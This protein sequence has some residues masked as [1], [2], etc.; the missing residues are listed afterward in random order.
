MKKFQVAQTSKMFKIIQV[1]E[2]LEN[3]YILIKIDGGIYDGQTHILEF[4]TKWGVS[5]ISYFPFNSPKV[6]FLTKI[7]HP[8][9]SVTGHI[10]VDIFTDSTKWSPLYDFES[11]ISTIMLLFVEPNNSSPYNNEAA[12]LYKRCINEFDNIKKDNMNQ[13]SKNAV[14]PMS[15]EDYLRTEAFKPYKSHADAYANSNNKKILDKY[16]PLFTTTIISDLVPAPQS[17]SEEKQATSSTSST[18]AIIT[19]LQKV[20]LR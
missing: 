11:V 14:L 15:V 8:N 2:S 16:L 12:I 4:Q 18:S 9:I 7:F 20:S 1:D 13:G 10:C 5:P 17:T 6:I 3:F 19:D